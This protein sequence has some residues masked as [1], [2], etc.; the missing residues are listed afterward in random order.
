MRATSRAPLDGRVAIVT[1]ASSGIGAATART[2]ADAGARV[3]LAAR[4]GDAL[5]A[6]ADGI[7]DGGGRAR[8]VP[9][10]VTDDGDVERLVESTLDAYGRLDVLVNNAGLIDVSPVADAD[11][12]AWERMVDV[13]LTG[14]M[15]ATNEALPALESGG[16]HVVTVSSVSDREPSAGYAGYDATKFGIRGFTEALRREAGEGLRVTLVSPGLV[17]TDL[18]DG[19]GPLADRMDEL[20]PLRPDDVADAVRYAVGQPDRVAVNELVIRPAGQ[21]R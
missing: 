5:E 2:L 18:P 16:G 17:D 12:D 11:F 14:A 8:A 10:D 4:S 13:N 9:T 20:T 1:G 19:D 6:I 21:D 3:V 7:E 15:R